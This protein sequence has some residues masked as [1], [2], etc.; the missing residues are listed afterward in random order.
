MGLDIIVYSNVVEI[1]NVTLDEYG[2]ADYNVHPT[3]NKAFVLDESFARSLRGLKDG[4][5]YEPSD[6]S[7]TMSF[8]A[9]SY[10]GYND[11]R[12]NLCVAALNVDPKEIWSDP[13]KYQD[14]PFFELINF[15]DNEGTIGPDAA[16]DLAYDFAVQRDE[17]YPQLDDYSQEKYD[18]WQEACEMARENGMIIFC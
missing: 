15:A 12:Y 7:D 3:A 6:E 18:L 14:E 11:F 17:I 4:A 8:R 10:S 9:G 5:W 13:E 1:E 16:R 2:Y